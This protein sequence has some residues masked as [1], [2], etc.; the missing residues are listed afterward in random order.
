MS[1]RMVM[2]FCLNLLEALLQNSELSQPYLLEL[3]QMIAE[4]NIAKVSGI[5]S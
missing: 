1:I 3:T 2:A 5:K 4:R